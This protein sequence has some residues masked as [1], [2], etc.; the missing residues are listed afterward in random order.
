MSGAGAVEPSTWEPLG[1]L[2]LLLLLLAL[3]ELAAGALREAG[4]DAWE[5]AKR[6]GRGWRWRCR[7]GGACRGQDGRRDRC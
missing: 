1:G 7:G 5:A 2:A 4:K 6:H 3:R